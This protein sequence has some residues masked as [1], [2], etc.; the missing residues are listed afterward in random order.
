M[1]VTPP[2]RARTQPVRPPQFFE[3]SGELV[4]AQAAG[5]LS[6]G[7]RFSGEHSWTYR[8]QNFVVDVAWIGEGQ[9]D[10]RSDLAEEHALLV[11]TGTAVEVSTAGST[12]TAVAGSA[13]VV[14]PAG[15]ARLEGTQAGFIVRVFSAR[16]PEVG[17]R[18]L[19]AASFSLPDPSILALP[20]LRAAGAEEATG[21]GNA[22]IRVH[23]LADVVDDPER[24][25]RIFRTES[26]MVN[27]F[28]P[29]IGPRDTDDLSPH[30]H[31]DFEQAS[32]TMAGEFVHHVRQPWTTRLQ[33][34][35]SDE[36]VHVHSPSVTII[37]PGNIHTT[38][39]IGDGMHELI[40]VFAPPRQDFIDRGWVLNQFEYNLSERNS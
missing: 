13:F 34:W 4:A 2:E 39:A 26:L 24:F 17:D 18:A 7:W 15:P 32:V 14:V 6:P 27:W 30:S 21:S 29:Q 8:T 40:D 1:P 38:R 12:A 5:V 3:F 35:R 28:E 23:R 37:P 10:E 36:H 33:D 31:P 19:N 9:V 25:G 22:G 11:M 16:S 20:P